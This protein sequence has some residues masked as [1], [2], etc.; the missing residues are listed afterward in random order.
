ML[1]FICYA[2]YNL[3]MQQVVRSLNKKQYR[4]FT[5]EARRKQI[6]DATIET[7]A[8]HGF[9]GTS[10]A[11]ISQCIGISRGL[12]SYHFENKN[13]L[14]HETYRAIYEAR[15]EAIAAATCAADTHI[16]RLEAAIQADLKFMSLHPAFF[17]A[18]VEIVFNVR[19]TSSLSYLHELHDPTLLSV[20]TVLEQGQKTGTFGLFDAQHMAMIIDGAKDQFLG[21]LITHPDMDATAYAHTLIEMVKNTIM[22]KEKS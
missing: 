11:T 10:F 17:A 5:E 4:T 6:I 14:L 20:Q 7:L 16:E 15:T 21:Q 3:V 12:I 9:V 13:E 22:K 19:D 18:L 2:F 8:H 1:A